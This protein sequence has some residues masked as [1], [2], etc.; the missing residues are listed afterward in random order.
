MLF[1]SKNRW[2]GGRVL[3]IL[4]GRKKTTGPLGY[5]WGKWESKSFHSCLQQ[6]F[7]KAWSI[8]VVLFQTPICLR[9]CSVIL[10]GGKKTTGP[11]GFGLSQRLIVRYLP[12]SKEYFEVARGM[13]VDFIANNKLRL[14]RGGTW[15]N[16][17]YQ[18]KC[19]AFS[20][21]LGL[22]WNKTNIYV[23]VG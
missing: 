18:F 17:K 14:D 4:V 5:Q 21:V 1:N 12:G 15:I 9:T 7:E 2:V 22:Y 20:R 23:N 3:S 6:Y 16:S 11:L 8:D 10:V 13:N 19:C